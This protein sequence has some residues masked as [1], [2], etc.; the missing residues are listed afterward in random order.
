MPWPPIGF[1]KTEFACR[2]YDL[3]AS[4]ARNISVTAVCSPC[5][6]PYYSCPPPKALDSQILPL[7]TPIPLWPSPKDL[8]PSAL[9]AH[10]SR[11]IKK[12]TIPRF[13]RPALRLHR[14]RPSFNDD[15]YIETSRPLRSRDNWETSKR[16]PRAF[17]LLSKIFGTY[18]RSFTGASHLR[19][20]DRHPS[21]HPASISFLARRAFWPADPFLG[22]T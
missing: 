13:D 2:G 10:L 19:D 6:R 18:P 3:S 22:R 12:S 11:F 20:G 7:L 21:G 15:V 16:N 1:R 8:G 9:P 4:N 17:G 14:R 5:T